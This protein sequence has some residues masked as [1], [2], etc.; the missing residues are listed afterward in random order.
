MF[1]NIEFSGGSMSLIDNDRV[2]DFG[3]INEFTMESTC[4]SEDIG[5]TIVKNTN[6][7]FE[8]ESEL[9]Y[10]NED[11]FNKLLNPQDYNNFSLRYNV[12]V[13]I[14]CRWHKKARI[15]K[16]WLK[17]YGMKSDV[18]PVVVDNCELEYNPGKTLG[19]TDDGILSTYNSY[20]VKTTQYPKYIFKPHQMRRGLKIS[21]KTY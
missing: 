8:F 10:F 9:T 11:L 17:R 12:P 1:D 7:S 5:D 3:N 16:K 14:Q 6:S 13:M 15:R 20:M 4:Q 2:I 19:Y 18:I 21:E